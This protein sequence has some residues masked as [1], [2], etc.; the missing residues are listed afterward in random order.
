MGRYT[1]AL[2]QF[3]WGQFFLSKAQW[4]V[5]LVILLKVFDMPMWTYFVIPIILVVF[6]WVL[7][8]FV[9]STGLRL[10]FIKENFKGTNIK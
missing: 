8:I 3:H 6:T 9:D 7:G 4:I 5:N 2:N 10:R 1:K